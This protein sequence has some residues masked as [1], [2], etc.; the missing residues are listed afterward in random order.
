MKNLWLVKISL[1]LRAHLFLCKPVCVCQHFVNVMN[2]SI[3]RYVCTKQLL[4]LV[5]IYFHCNN[6]KQKM[7]TS[8]TKICYNILCL[9]QELCIINIGYWKIVTAERPYQWL[10]HSTVC[11]CESKII[12]LDNNL[13][14]AN[15]PH[16]PSL[17]LL[18]LTVTS[19]LTS[20]KGPIWTNV[21]VC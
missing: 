4:L 7:C 19:K 18:D 5:L 3:R 2:S 8:K 13:Q 15:L 12:I 11:I 6:H 16:Q 17:R 20:Q 21:C 10:K 1:G 9:L 14:E